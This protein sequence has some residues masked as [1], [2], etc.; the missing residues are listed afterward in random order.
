VN[1]EPGCF[2][3]INGRMD[4]RTDGHEKA[5]SRFSQFCQSA[6][7]LVTKSR[8]NDFSFI[9]STFSFSDKG[10]TLWHNMYCF[11]IIYS[12]PFDLIKPFFLGTDKCTLIYKT[13]CIHKWWR[14]LLSWMKN[15]INIMFYI[16]FIY[17][18]IRGFAPTYN[19]GY[20]EI[21]IGP[22]NCGA[23]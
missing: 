20:R 17:N 11:D 13:V 8:P 1:W 21:K 10:N 18:I 22:T 19:L 15:F 4:G 14:M 23:M 5:N 6:W 7:I 3:R 12:V 9:H 16:N 2:M